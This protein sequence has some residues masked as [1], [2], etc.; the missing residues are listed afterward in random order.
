MEPAPTGHEDSAAGDPLAGPEALARAFASVAGDL[1]LVLDVRG[2]VQA[3]A[4]GE[5]GAGAGWA[6]H[7]IG[8]SWPEAVEPG[9]QAKAERLLAEALRSGEARGR[10]INLAADDGH[11]MAFRCSALRLGP[12]G[13][14]LVVGRDLGAQAALQRQLV[15]LQQEMETRYWEAAAVM[16][17]GPA[18]RAPITPRRRR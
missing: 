7:W 3:A 5:D 16:A 1:A 12:A 2:R 18:R 11:L 6:S 14:V 17:A 8:R 10:E 4:Q 9:S 15:T 13:P